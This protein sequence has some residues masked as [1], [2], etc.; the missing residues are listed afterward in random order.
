MS[1][2]A[3]GGGEATVSVL[4]YSEFCILFSVFY[5]LYGYSQFIKIISHFL[6]LPEFVRLVTQKMKKISV[7]QNLVD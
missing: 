3:G 7:G 5:G 6:L 2:Y 1:M 4:K